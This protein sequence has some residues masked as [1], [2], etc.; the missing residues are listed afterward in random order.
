MQVDRDGETN[1]IFTAVYAWPR[2]QDREVLWTELQH[3]QRSSSLGSS[4]AILMNR[5]P[6]QMEPWGC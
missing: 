6:G 3:E 5:H 4:R 2:Q 1:W